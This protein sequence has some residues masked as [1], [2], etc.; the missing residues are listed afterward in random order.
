MQARIRKEL[1]DFQKKKN[2]GAGVEAEVVGKDM[3]HWIGRL[4][5]PDDTPYDGGIF[6]VD[7]KIPDQYPFAPPKVTF[8]T[9]LW[10][11]N[12]SSQTGAI[13]LDILKDQ[14]SPAMTIRTV[15]LSLQALL[16][17]PEPDDPQDAQVAQQ[18]KKD[19]NAFNKQAAEWT[20]KYAGKGLSVKEQENAIKTLMEMGIKR[21]RARRELTQHGWDI[22]A[23]INACF[24]N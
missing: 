15:L 6:T 5:G 2:D 18:Y 20:K 14:W 9:R 10:H 13:C 12:V 11:P 7:I 4:K 3:Q 1:K 23:A 8:N 24:G 19:R 22:E 21:D 17:A 16:C